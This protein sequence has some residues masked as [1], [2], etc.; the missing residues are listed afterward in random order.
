MRNLT[1]QLDIFQSCTPEGG[2]PPSEKM[3]HQIPLTCLS[4]GAGQ[5]VLLYKF[6]YDASF[7][8]KYAP[9]RLL[10]VCADTG[11]EHDFT[12]K[13]IEET[14]LF[15]KEQNIEFHFITNDMG[16]HSESWM[17]LRGFYRLKNTI[18]SRCFP[19]TC[20]SRLKINVIYSFLENWLAENYKVAN[21]RKKGFKEFAARYGKINMVIGIAAGEEKRI[22][23]NEDD[24]LV[25]RKCAVQSIYPLI[26]LGMDRAACQKYI[27]SVG[28]TIPMPSNCMCCPFLS[29]VE[30]LWLYKLRREVYE[31]WVQ[32]EANKIANNTHIEPER[33]LGVWGKKLLPEVLAEAIEKYGDWTDD[34]LT[35]YKMSHGHC[36]TTKY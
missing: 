4:F 1:Y 3:E 31:D 9:G 30:L 25:W 19:K 7:R 35:E 20:S 2:F 10:V 8:E 16:Y 23:K 18:G 17:S 26:D 6:A 29:P 5:P 36:V 28:H 24:P 15:C 22:A 14:K 11:D 12:Y 21:G 32:L 27:L 34:E 13:H 33:N